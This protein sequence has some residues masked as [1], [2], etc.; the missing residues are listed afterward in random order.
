M[1]IY[2]FTIIFVI[3]ALLIVIVKES[4]LKECANDEETYLTYKKSV[5]KATEAAAWELRAAGVNFSDETGKR[6][7]DAF[8][9]SLYASMGIIDN[10]SERD[11]V[12]DDFPSFTVFLDE[13]Y[14]IYKGVW[15]DDTGKDRVY[16][17]YGMLKYDEHTR[18]KVGFSCTCSNPLPDDLGETIISSAFVAE[19]DRFIIDK[20]NI[21]HVEGC[22]YAGDA[23]CTVFSKEGCAM[24]GA[25]PCKKCID[26]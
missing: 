2:H 5:E 6:A 25:R 9:Y 4:E 24:L 15:E 13:G 12:R 26:Q 7:I 8:F 23:E 17:K 19:G 21:Y 22:M 1:K 14:Y 20:E 18:G 11:D 3:F 16:E 10:V